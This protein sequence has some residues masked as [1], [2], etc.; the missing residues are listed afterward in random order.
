[1]FELEVV[2]T[3]YTVLVAATATVICKYTKRKELKQIN[4][5]LLM[6]KAA[7]QCAEAKIQELTRNNRKT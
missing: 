6:L 1:M 3:S 2:I 4:E 7:L 5:N